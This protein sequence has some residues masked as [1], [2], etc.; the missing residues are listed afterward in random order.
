M[1]VDSRDEVAERN[2][3]HGAGDE[4]GDGK[5]QPARCGLSA[6]CPEFWRPFRVA[7]RLAQRPLAAG[8]RRR[9]NR[10]VDR[11]THW[12]GL[13]SLGPIPTAEA[14]R[15]A[16]SRSIQIRPPHRS[17]RA[18]KASSSEGLAKFQ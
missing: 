13:L 11:N 9:A 1:I 12:A 15:K 6:I 3:E 16:S 7:P 8:R 17:D 18:K 10:E 2:H 14:E 5:E 4:H